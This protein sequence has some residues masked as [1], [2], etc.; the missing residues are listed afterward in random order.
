MGG[1]DDHLVPRPAGPDPATGGGTHCG[2]R[3]PTG[4][5][6]VLASQLAPTGAD[7]D[8]PPAGTEQAGERRSLHHAHAGGEQGCGV[9]QHVAR[10][11]EPTV[12]CEVRRPE[13]QAGSQR[14]V[15]GV[16]L[17][18][19]DPD[20]LQPQLML[21]RDPLV[22]SRDLVLGEARHEVAGLDEAGVDAEF[23]RLATVEVLAPPA[24]LDRRRRTPLR[25]HHSSGPRGRP[26]AQSLYLQ[27][28]D[29]Q[30]RSA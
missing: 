8:G 12:A 21:H 10:R 5:H 22:R 27:Q 28:R 26:F 25:S 18:R 19:L 6:D 17:I 4:Q 13:R 7:S 14:W 16:D 11:V 1:G 30:A 20:R 29:A 3:R 23:V 15:R 24:Q 2:Q 9:G